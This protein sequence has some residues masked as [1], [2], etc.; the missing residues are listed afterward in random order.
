MRILG[1][2][3]AKET[4]LE[5]EEEVVDERGR[6]EA[7]GDGVVDVCD[8]LSRFVGGGCGSEDVEDLEREER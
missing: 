5:D 3:S 6:D 8:C 7:M 4:V 2:G 1:G